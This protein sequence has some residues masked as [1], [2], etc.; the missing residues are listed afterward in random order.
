MATTYSAHILFSLKS[1]HAH[2]H[3]A[4]IKY[5]TD[6]TLKVKL[7]E[8]N[9]THKTHVTFNVLLWTQDGEESQ[10]PFD[11]QRRRTVIVSV[12]S[13]STDV[14]LKNENWLQNKILRR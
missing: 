6:N 5:G 8:E 13:I 1:L 3:L 14:K 10:M 7:E 4:L 12:G 9:T 11:H 2:I